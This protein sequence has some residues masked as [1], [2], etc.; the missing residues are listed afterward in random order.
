[1]KIGILYCG[2]LTKHGKFM[3]KHLA[4][5]CFAILLVSAS[6]A[7]VQST[8]VTAS[9]LA[10][11]FDLAGKHAPSPQFFVME[12]KLIMYALDGKRLG[13]DIYRLRLKC[14]PAPAGKDGDEYTCARFTWQP[15][16]GAETTIPASTNWT[17]LFE[18]TGQ[19]EKGQVFGIDHS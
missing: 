12:S 10:K 19:D 4:Y 15:H 11:T 5:F 16:G 17:Y 1:M 8:S 3:T 9:L 14:I 13:T 18:T 6:F 7:G 2:K